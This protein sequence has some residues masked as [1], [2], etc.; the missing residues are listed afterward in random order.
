MPLLPS[1][2]ARPLYLGA[3]LLGLVSACA[4]TQS[5][6]TASYGGTTVSTFADSLGYESATHVDPPLLTKTV[7]ILPFKR[8][9]GELFVDQATPEQHSAKEAARVGEAF[10]NWCA[11]NGGGPS[12]GGNASMAFR[13]AAQ[14]YLAQRLE[15]RS[16]RPDWTVSTE[17]C[18]A[19]DGKALAGFVNLNNADVAFY[20]GPTLAAF[21]ERFE[22]LAKERAR[23]EADATRAKE[24]GDAAERRLRDPAPE[25][26]PRRRELV[27]A[28]AP[29]VRDYGILD[30]VRYVDSCVLRVETSQ[31]AQEIFLGAVD[32]R[33]LE[34]VLWNDVPTVGIVYHPYIGDGRAGVKLSIKDK[35]AAA[36]IVH[37]IEELA[38]TCR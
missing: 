4:T 31:T 9:L 30:D 37:A 2:L 21:V 29:I 25:N 6:L 11:A 28:L 20:D 5:P 36:R 27:A 13:T 19:A 16:K 17:T 15:K 33:M 32:R 18:L 10:G 26:E 38:D 3:V 23:S 14:E 8:T 7:K 34:N 1:P 12:Q 35:D 22:G 24:L